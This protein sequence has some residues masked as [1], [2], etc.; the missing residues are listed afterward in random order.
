MFTWLLKHTIGTK[1][2]RDIKRLRPIVIRINEIEREYQ[3]LSDEQ[4][5]AKTDEF[6][7]RL[8][9]GETLDDILPEAY[10]AVKNACRRLVG[11]R[12]EVC[13]L[14]T[15]WDM[16]P[17]DVQLIGAVVLHQGKIAEM[18]TGEGKTLV[19]TMP[20][21]LNSLTGKSV[22]LVTVNDYLARR[23]A[24]WM[25]PV[26]GMLG[27][28][29]G[30][31]QHDMPHED[32]REAYRRDITYGTNSEFGFD[33]LRDNGMAMSLEEQVQR[34]HHY[35]I[36]DE[37]A[38][39]LIDEARTPLIISG[40]VVVSTQQ[41]DK[42][43][44]RAE[45]LVR[46]Q[47]FLCNRLVTEAKEMLE[48][49]ETR[50]EAGRKLYLV[51]RGAPKNKQFL[52]LMEDPQV[53]KL[54]DRV[55]LDLRADMKKEERFT[56]L[57]ELYYEIDEKGHDI[58]I[59]EKGHAVLDPSGQHSFVMP[60]IITG[61]QEIDEDAALGPEEKERRK[62]QLQQ[63]QIEIG[64]KLHGLTQLI[65]AYALYEKDVQYVV[66]DNR[67]IIV[68]EF[69]GRLMPG[70]RWSD[71]LHQAV[72]AK[73]GVRIEQEPQTFA[74]I[75]I[76]NYFRLYEKLAGM[77]GTAETEAHEFHQIYKLDV[78]V[79]PTNEAVRRVDFNDVIYKTRREKYNAVV[80][81]IEALH[82]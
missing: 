12:W 80:E 46:R 30:C 38:S 68:D 32:R 25:G 45:E 81:E 13:G 71:G 65:R 59:K 20:L 10:A 15:E 33:Y 35:A 43:K 14:E 51:S 37:V 3:A 50:Y 82:R 28:T 78:V 53:R 26:Y 4:L 54:I 42:L 27:V 11:K 18:A 8:A 31:I 49:E 73:E 44:P 60:D 77:T 62:L 19:A 47:T 24:Q 61:F 41:Y 74:T 58:D 6:K 36:V 56:L 16:V 39:L 40:P 5:R 9:D 23:D 2:D 52:K 55:D 72:E 66:Q 67:V 48:K 17:F 7:K 63:R 70:R 29:V 34:G 22:H 79:I 1:H 75:T 21:Y 76:Q 57:E 64:E 69:T